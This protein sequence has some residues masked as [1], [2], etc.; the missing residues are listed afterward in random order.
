M[1]IV[2]DWLSFIFDFSSTRAALIRLSVLVIIVIAAVLIYRV[3]LG[4]KPRPI[5]PEGNREI[6]PSETGGAIEAFTAEK[7]GPNMRPGIPDEA[8]EGRKLERVLFG[9]FL[10]AVAV[11][12]ILPVYFLR[13][14]TRSRAE[15][16]S[17][18][19]QSI[20]R[21]ATL[22]ANAGMPGYDSTKSLAC[23][24]CHGAK[25]EG[26]SVQTVIQPQ[27]PGD[28]PHR[29]TWSAPA[30]DSVL[31]RFPRDEQ[32]QTQV[33]DII[34]YGRPGTPMQP[35]GVA[36]GGAKGEQAISDIVNYLETITITPGAAKKVSTD[37]LVDPNASV[38]HTS[39]TQPEAN[40]ATKCKVLYDAHIAVANTLNQVVDP[41]AEALPGSADKTTCDDL[42]IAERAQ[43]DAQRAFD[44]AGVKPTAE[45]QAAIDLANAAIAPA[46]LGVEQA[47]Q[48]IAER[49]A[50]KVRDD[51]ASQQLYQTDLASAHQAITD[52]EAALEK[53]KKIGAP[54]KIT[55]A[56]NSLKGAQEALAALEKAGPTDVWQGRLVFEN[57]CARCH[58]EAWSY[59]DPN[60]PYT[61]PTPDATGSGAFGPNLTGGDS[62]RQFPKVVDQVQFVLTGSQ[63]QKQYGV[64]GI[65]SGR[66]PGF[67]NVLTNEQI[68]QV[69]QF[70]RSL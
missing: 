10:M 26:G 47:R 67:A 27:F 28:V 56:E 8:L 25:G 35:W 32:G 16:L 55:A 34:T 5:G 21:G 40:L 9:A 43:A 62:L 22:Y 39:S 4:D 33:T 45:Q 11:A 7:P 60:D 24:N 30:L 69:V 53:A 20:A 58:T 15:T 68:A 37:L 51:A 38:G 42:P 6:V 41:K 44:N 63:Y 64:R 61:E 46:Q 19:E 29:V 49:D 36:G 52:A 48:W 14:P 1:G 59:F 12:I 18:K 31:L 66:M 70:E 3:T 54:D 13:E 50:L 65:G 57:N 17:F 23:A 2:S